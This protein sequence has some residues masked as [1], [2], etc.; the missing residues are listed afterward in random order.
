MIIFC[1]SSDLAASKSNNSVIADGVLLFFTISLICS[2]IKVPPGSL[3]L[4]T[5]KWDFLKD[6]ESILQCVVFP[7]PSP[8]SIVM[9]NP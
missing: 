4:T 6:S 9:K 3:T 7:T 1:I 2:P 5:S 8:P